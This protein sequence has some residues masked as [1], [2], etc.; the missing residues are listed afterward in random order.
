MSVINIAP[1]RSNL[2]QQ[3]SSLVFAREGYTILD[4]KREVLTM[5]LLGMVNRAEEQQLKVTQLMEKAYNALELAWLTMGREKV[6]WAAISVN[7]TTE[8]DVINH[9]LMGVPLP[10][11]DT[12]GTPPT[13]TYSLADTTA[14]LDEASQ[15]FKEVLAEI[16]LLASLEVSVRR[17]AR[18]LKKTQRR[19]NALER[20]FIPNLEDTI[21]FIQDNLEEQ[22]REEIF[23]MQWLRAPDKDA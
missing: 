16:P 2:L 22:D 13:L 1:T 15:A 23:R 9:G 12:H 19:V 3:K 20:I 21:R 10:R 17:I 11:I 4:K 18:E 7:G 14:F 5:E 6:E 8:L